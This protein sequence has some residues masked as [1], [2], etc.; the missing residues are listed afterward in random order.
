L[1]NKADDEGRTEIVAALFWTLI[2]TIT[3]MFFHLAVSF[4]ISSPTF[5]AFYEQI[6]FYPIYSLRD[7][8]DPTWGPKKKQH[9]V[10]HLWSWGSLTNQMSSL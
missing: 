3:L 4:C 2:S 6:T 7:P 9:L 10:H 5:L 1:I 8:K